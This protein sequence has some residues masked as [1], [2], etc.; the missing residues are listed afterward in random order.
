MGNNHDMQIPYIYMGAV[1]LILSG[2]PD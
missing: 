2:L 1:G